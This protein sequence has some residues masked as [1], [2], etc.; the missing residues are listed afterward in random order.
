MTNKKP[1]LIALQLSFLAG[2]GIIFQAST[3]EILPRDEMY[4]VYTSEYPR[5]RD[6]EWAENVQGV[7]HD[8]D[9]WYITQTRTLWKIPLDIDINEAARNTQNV[10][11]ID[12]KDIPQLW[13]LGYD[14]FGDLS[15]YN[16]QKGT[17]LLVPLEDD[18]RNEPDGAPGAIAIFDA[19][20]LAYIDHA[21]INLKAAP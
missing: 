7:T 8:N 10:Q 5:D 17:Y 11:I 16:Y 4:Y 9:H 12:L 20:T 13:D 6:A 1:L 14:H 19:R 15:Y 18:R 21:E 2:L 3:C